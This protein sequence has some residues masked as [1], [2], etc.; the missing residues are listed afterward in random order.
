MTYKFMEWPK[1][2]MT[3]KFMEQPQPL[4][5]RLAI[6]TIQNFIYTLLD[7]VTKFVCSVEALLNYVICHIV[8]ILFKAK[9]QIY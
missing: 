8:Y 9:Y 4:S 1:N 6:L 7:C 3:Y 2:G 5:R